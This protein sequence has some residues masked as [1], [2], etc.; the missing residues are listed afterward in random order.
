L[1]EK[2]Q[3]QS[4]TRRSHPQTSRN[5]GRNGGYQRGSLPAN[6]GRHGACDN[7]VP[8]YQ[9]RVD[10]AEALEPRN[11]Q[12]QRCDHLISQGRT[13]Q[14][15]RW[16][17]S[18]ASRQIFSLWPPTRSTDLKASQQCGA[19]PLGGSPSPLHSDR[20]SAQGQKVK[21]SRWGVRGDDPAAE[22]R[23]LLSP[24]EGGGQ[25]TGAT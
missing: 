11:S 8:S 18:L 10:G 17:A 12:G 19:F 5:R 4:R 20:T 22:R 9:V 14:C 7:M 24:R 3:A 25:A 13:E 1:F 21:T 6:L 2:G 15:Q 23:R 16:A